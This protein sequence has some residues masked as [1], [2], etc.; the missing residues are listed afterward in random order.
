MLYIQYIKNKSIQKYTNK[1]VINIISYYF[2]NFNPVLSFLF[3]L[4]FLFPLFFTYY[5]SISLFTENFTKKLFTKNYWQRKLKK[6]QVLIRGA[7]G[8][9]LSGLEL[10][11]IMSS[12]V[13]LTHISVTRETSFNKSNPTSFILIADCS[14]KKIN[15]F[16]FFSSPN[17]SCL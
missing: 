5:F 2:L 14:L 1:Y 4:I 6:K 7:N 9:C 8:W 13:K 15:N 10:A 11:G 12:T 3:V 16:F 17:C